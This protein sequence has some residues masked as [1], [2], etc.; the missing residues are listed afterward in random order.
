MSA[1]RSFSRWAKEVAEDPQYPNWLDRDEA[2]V[3]LYV[4]LTEYLAE[5][6]SCPGAPSFAWIPTERHRI[7][8]V[9]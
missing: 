5:A 9:N 7:H 3:A 6:S 1:T 8:L 4:A 2:T